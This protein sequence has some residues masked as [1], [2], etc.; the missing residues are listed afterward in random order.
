[1]ANDT[2]QKLEEDYTDWVM[3]AEQREPFLELGRELGIKHHK[4]GDQGGARQR[5]VQ[6]ALTLISRGFMEGAVEVLEEGE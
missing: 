2:Q 5:I 3:D 6:E 4:E 1:M